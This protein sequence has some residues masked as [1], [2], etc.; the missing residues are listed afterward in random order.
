MVCATGQLESQH[1]DNGSGHVGNHV[2]C[3]QRQCREGVQA[4]DAGEGEVFPESIVRT[5]F[6]P[7]VRLSGKMLICWVWCS[8]SKQIIEHERKEAAKEVAAKGQQ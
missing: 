3:F 6:L 7:L 4:Q 8:W 1:G 2:D 5:R